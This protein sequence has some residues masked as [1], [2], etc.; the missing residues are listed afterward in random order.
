MRLTNTQLQNFIGRIKLK[1]E[2]MPKYREQI[3]NLREKLEQKI[4]ELLGL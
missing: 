2:N 3:K 1:E 4:K